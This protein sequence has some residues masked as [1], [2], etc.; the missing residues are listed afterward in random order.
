MLGFLELPMLAAPFA[1]LALTSL[2]FP[3]ASFLGHLSGIAVGLLVSAPG[4]SRIAACS[5]IADRMCRHTHLHS[6]VSSNGAQAGV[7]SALAAQS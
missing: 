2:I 3:Q 1:S 5:R 4:V 7:R 6:A